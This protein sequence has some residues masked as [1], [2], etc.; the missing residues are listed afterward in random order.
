MSRL[1][2]R[3][4]RRYLPWYHVTAVV[5]KSVIKDTLCMNQVFRDESTKRNRHHILQGPYYLWR[6]LVLQ[7]ATYVITWLYCFVEV[8]WPYGK[9]DLFFMVRDSFNAWGQLD[10]TPT[11]YIAC[12]VKHCSVTFHLLLL[13]NAAGNSSKSHRNPILIK[14]YAKHPSTC[15]IR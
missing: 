6:N 3:T 7:C 8:M 12:F 2:Y 4:E 1:L 13:L 14:R 15:D 10:P 5:L 11:Q 9:T